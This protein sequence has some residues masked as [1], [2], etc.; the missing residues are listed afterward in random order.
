LTPN[1]VLE[2][3]SQFLSLHK[4][5]E[6]TKQYKVITYSIPFSS[7]LFSLSPVLS[8]RL[9][10]FG[11]DCV[12]RLRNYLVV[13]HG[14]LVLIFFLFESQFFLLPVQAA[15]SLVSTNNAQCD[16]AANSSD[17]QRRNISG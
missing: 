16:T 5:K 14:A 13:A 9:N 15:R 2:G 7:I 12:E 3:F 1:K 11:F 8:L 17:S 6:C 10:G 4:T